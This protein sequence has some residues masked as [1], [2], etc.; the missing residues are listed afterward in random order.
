MHTDPAAHQDS[1]QANPDRS[2]SWN[3][4]EHPRMHYPLSEKR[5]GMDATLHATRLCLMKSLRRNKQRA[6]GKPGSIGRMRLP[7]HDREIYPLAM[8]SG[9]DTMADSGLWPWQED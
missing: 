7:K 9:V 2:F 3:I 8:F 6:T 5:A 1:D 4:G